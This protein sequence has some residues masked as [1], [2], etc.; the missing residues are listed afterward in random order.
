MKD[1]P[2]P[3]SIERTQELTRRLVAVPKHEIE[4]RERKWRKR[5][6]RPAPGDRRERESPPPPLPP[7]GS[8]CGLFVSFNYLLPIGIETVL[9]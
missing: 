1:K 4:A 3:D 8:P 6:T 2:L 9:V 5:R 7:C